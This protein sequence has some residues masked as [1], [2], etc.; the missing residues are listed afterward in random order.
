MI[1]SCCT[2]SGTNETNKPYL[3]F[4]C[5]LYSE[6]TIFYQFELCNVYNHVRGNSRKGFGWCRLSCLCALCRGIKLCNKSHISN[7]FVYWAR[8]RNEARKQLSTITPQHS[9]S[10]QLYK[11]EYS[12]KNNIR[13]I[14]DVWVSSSRNSKVS[15]L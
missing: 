10:C 2:I 11:G 8:T 1:K 5:S 4:H 14:N 9:C 7:I 15:K 13:N 6:S 3:Y 12:N